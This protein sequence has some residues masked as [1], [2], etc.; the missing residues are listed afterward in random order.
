MKIYLAGPEVFLE[1]A[2]TVGQQ[3]KDLCAKYGFTALYPLDGK[4]S[5]NTTDTMPKTPPEIGIHIYHN[6]IHFM[7]E[8]DVIIANMTPYQ[9]V[10]MDTGTAFEMGYMRGLGK[11][12]YG[13]SNVAELFNQRQ[14]DAFDYFVDDNHKMRV[15]DTRMAIE[16]FDLCDNLMMVGAVVDT[17]QK[18][19]M[20]AQKT[21][22]NSIETHTR[23]DIFEQVLQYIEK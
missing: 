2:V 16:N 10:G 22:V 21:S 7:N 23:L 20:L 9:G 5:D 12:V 11:P 8:A 15:T 6:N 18:P 4:N 19:P 14:K 1:N 13:Y 3:K 17:T